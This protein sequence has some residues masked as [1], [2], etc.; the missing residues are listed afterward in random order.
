MDDRE[1]KRQRAA[2][3]AMSE[4]LEAYGWKP[5]SLITMGSGFRVETPLGPR[6]LKRFRYGPQEMSFVYDVVEHLRS[7]GFHNTPRIYLTR[8]GDPY[9]FAGGETLY[10]EDWHD[11]TPL[12]VNDPGTLSAVSTV[13]AVMH[14]AAEGYRPA[15]TLTGVR[16]NYGSWLEES[17]E[18]LRD[19][20]G[21]A[22][23]A[24]KER[25]TS[26]W[27][28]RFA[29]AAPAFCKQAEEAVRLLAESPLREIVR[30]EREAG[31]V[32]HGNFAP[33]N[34]ALD[35]RMQLCVLDFDNCS[36]EIRLDDLAKFISRAA[37]LDLDRA[38]FIMQCYGQARG[39]P[40]SRDEIT[41]IG[42]YLLFPS[43]FWAVGRSRFHR[44]HPR[45]RA[46][47]RLIENGES[48]AR[49]AAVVGGLTLPPEPVLVTVPGE[50]P[51]EAAGAADGAAG[52]AAH[53]G[54]LQ[55]P[56]IPDG[57]HLP[58]MPVEPD[59]VTAAPIGLLRMDAVTPSAGNP[60]EVPFQMSEETPVYQAWPEEAPEEAPEEEQGALVFAQPAPE[61]DIQDEPSQIAGEIVPEAQEAK[62]AAGQR[63]V[64]GPMPEPVMSIPEQTAAAT[65]EE[66]GVA[67]ETEPGG[68]PLLDQEPVQSAAVD[69][70][71]QEASLETPPDMS[72]EPVVLVEDAVAESPPAPAKPAQAVALLE[73]P[74]A[75]PVAESVVEAVAEMVAETVAEPSE[76][77]EVR[78]V[79]PGPRTIVWGKWPEPVKPRE[80]N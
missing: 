5:S 8:G 54:P 52:A 41:V 72:P 45:E 34:L 31:A 35:T 18:R 16:D 25:R 7:R 61:V 65:G 14:K 28:S 43:E 74:V 62:P 42:A 53:A 30:L 9:V 79:Q 71:I 22:E 51:A 49:F 70:D 80:E 23:L 4:A 63:L 38:A 40:L 68:I 26:K 69:Q 29:R 1:F 47:R 17:V 24:E 2:Y 15:G 67:G 55:A 46:L 11:L 77:P 3:E 59:I 19:L 36:R 20:Y 6:F 32:S 56:G 12:D 57:P 27:D 60:K 50:G 21:F 10:L 76:E 66:D 39:T 75:E 58:A 48:L 73:E 64:W 13:M 78:T 33:R 37:A 44:D